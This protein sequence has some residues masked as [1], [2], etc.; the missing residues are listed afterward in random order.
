LVSLLVV[1]DSDYIRDLLK[2]ILEQAGHIIVGEASNANEAIK[3]YQML[4]PEIVLMDMV[5]EPTETGKTGLDALNEILT[6]D[7]TA[8]IIVCSALN[9]QILINEA[10]AAGAKGFVPK[11]FDPDKLLEIILYTSDLGIMV[12]IGN[13]GAGRALTSLSKLTNQSINIEVPKIE[14]APAHLVSLIKWSP[15]QPVTAVHMGLRGQNECDILLA[16]ELEEA[17]KISEIMTEKILVSNASKIQ[18]SAIT[19]MSSITICSFF[20]AI[21]DFLELKLLPFGP[22]LVTDSFEAT[23]DTFLANMTVSTETAVLFNIR[24]KKEKSTVDGVLIIFISPE[25]QKKLI[26]LGKQWMNA[27]EQPLEPLF[28]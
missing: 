13:M 10:M 11:P 7:P 6:K 9:E 22:T 1:D 15:D 27:E 14:T 2:T 28:A 8:K 17:A 23:L 24:L 4:H 18:A 19:E 20:S 26:T 21:S 12:E 5:L 25:F 3:K 16:F